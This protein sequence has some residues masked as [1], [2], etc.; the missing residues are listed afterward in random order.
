MKVPFCAQGRIDR[1]FMDDAS[2]S[3]PRPRRVELCGQ[4]AQKGTFMQD[5]GG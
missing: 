5:G 3:L 2:D 4:H 1:T